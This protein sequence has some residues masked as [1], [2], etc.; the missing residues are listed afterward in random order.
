VLGKKILL[1]LILIPNLV[2]AESFVLVCEGKYKIKM[3]G[4]DNIY[5]ES[6]KL[7]VGVF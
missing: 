5:L 2:M 6:G 1:L 7:A 3:N 4:D